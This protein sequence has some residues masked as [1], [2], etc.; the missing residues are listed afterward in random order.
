MLTIARCS[1]RR[2]L[3]LLAL[4]IGSLADPI[5]AQTGPET[6][7]RAE[8]VSTVDGLIKAVYKVI[9]GPKDQP[10]DWARMRTLFFPGARMVPIVIQP[11][12]SVAVPILSVDD[13]IAR[14]GPLI[15][16]IG[17][18]EREVARR[19]EQFGNVT[20]VWST[21]EGTGEG[22]PPLR[23]INS[24]QLI[25]DGTRWWILHLVWDH[26]RP[27]LTI[28]ERYRTSP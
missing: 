18:Q 13:Y 14:S 4:C 8:D 16:R 17:F 12:G 22:L 20:H 15:E 5:H 7:A 2:T 26:E 11:A 10:R 6:G 23:G 27:G 28:P 21:Y 1:T 24:I 3:A 25:N 9:S 19:I